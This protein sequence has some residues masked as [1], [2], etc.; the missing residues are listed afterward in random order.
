MTV[1][2]KNQE[3]ATVV[4]RNQSAVLK[5]IRYRG[6]Q[7]PFSE[8]RALLVL[9]DALLVLLAVWV[10]FVL[11]QYGSDQPFNAANIRARIGAHWIW[12]PILLG[13][14]WAVAWLNDLYDIP[15]SAHKALSTARVVATGVLGLLIYMVVFFF[16][17]QYRPPRLF[18]IYFLLVA[19]PAII[20]WRWTY[21]AVSSRLPIQ[22]WVLI[23]GGGERARAIAKA[24]KQ[25]SPV[26]YHVTGF[27][28]DDP[29]MR[30]QVLDGMPMLGR[31]GDLPWLVTHLEIQEIV[32]A[33]ERYVETDLFQLLVDCHGLGARVSY[34]PDLYDKLSRRI[35]IQHIDP[36]WALNVLER[37]PSRLSLSFKRLVD[38]AL[39]GV[40]LL[41]FAPLLPLVALAIRLDSPGPV[42]YRQIRSGRAGRPFAIL[43]FRT[44]S[45]DAEKDGRARWATEDDPRIT[46]VGR[47]LRKTRLDELPQLHNVLR[48]EMSIVGPRPE[49]PE[50]IE[51]LEQDI[52]FYRTRLMVKPGLTGWA[53]I[54]YRYGNSVEDALIKLQYDFYYL[55]YWSLLL[56]LYI[57]FRTF[58]VALRFKGT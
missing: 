48:G 4:T 3:I 24:L 30:G 5:N 42:F 45:T 2:A 17:A 31:T 26:S 13:G 47:F 44:M 57:I 43:K 32:V 1:Q 46:R 8:R 25:V 23:V 15:T 21:A 50:F 51:Q 27:V 28:D 56:D 7:A 37:L 12:F 6:F 19:V 20:L 35:P 54:H 49:R 52:P 14:W 36:A 41:V 38:L 11:W 39:A 9:G 53:Q 55:R 29:A 22:H 40:G 58:G 18:L 10:A 33:T 16:L 34:M